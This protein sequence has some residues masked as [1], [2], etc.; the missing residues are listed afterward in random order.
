ML[1]LRTTAREAGIARSCYQ[2]IS[3]TTLMHTHYPL[4]NNFT[5]RPLGATSMQYLLRLLPALV[6]MAL[7]ALSGNNIWVQFHPHAFFTNWYKIR[8]RCLYVHPSYLNCGTIQW[9]LIKCYT[10]SLNVAS[11]IGHRLSVRPHP[12]RPWGAQRLL[13]SCTKDPFT[14][15][16][17]APEWGRPFVAACTVIFKMRRLINDELPFI[18]GLLYRSKWQVD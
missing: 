10:G 2:Y 13:Y 12:H 5:S 6:K 7:T 9:A 15:C 18:F 8:R 17:A 14:W 11:S 3:K 4:N 16:K 1:N